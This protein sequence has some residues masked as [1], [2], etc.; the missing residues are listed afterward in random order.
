M[1]A[2]L[3][4]GA[5]GFG[6]LAFTSATT[7]YLVVAALSFICG[8]GMAF[9][10]PAA[11]AAAVAA[12]PA[13]LAGTASG[14]INMARRTGTV[15]GVA[16]LG[17]FAASNGFLAGFQSGFQPAH[18]PSITNTLIFFDVQSIAPLPSPSCGDAVA[19]ARPCS[20]NV[21]HPPWSLVAGP[22]TY[23]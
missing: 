20:V 16:T 2:G 13:N 22:P 9:A 15:I 6:G 21:N 5:A 11:T 12:A 19:L 14:V 7:P 23:P 4:I 10:M 17:A 1:L 3:L 8:F 18:Q